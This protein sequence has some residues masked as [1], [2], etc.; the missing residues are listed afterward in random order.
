MEQ[1]RTGEQAPVGTGADGR[2]LDVVLV[3][4]TI[5]EGP[6]A[7]IDIGRLLGTLET[8][9]HTGHVRVVGP[10]FW[11]LVLLVSGRIVAA[12]FSDG[13]VGL[14][15]DREDALGWLAWRAE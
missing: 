8:D 3:G 14:V 9:A 15:T 12:R 1:E 7:F 10:G 4:P 11:G 5:Y 6:T 13:R 2:A